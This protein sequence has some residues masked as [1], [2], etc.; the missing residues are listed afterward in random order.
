VATLISS[1]QIEPGVFQETWEEDARIYH[2]YRDE[3]KAARNSM[4]AELRKAHPKQGYDSPF[5]G[6]GYIAPHERHL[7]ELKYP[8][9]KNPDPRENFKA[10]KRF[11][12]S[13]VSEPYRTV[14][15][16]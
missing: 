3:A 9:L 4:R 5:Q 12:T 16:V 7:L 10:W 14:D 8:Y 1:R 15:R 11:W 6:V 2:C 13:S